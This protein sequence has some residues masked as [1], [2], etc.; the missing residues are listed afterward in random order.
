MYHLNKYYHWESEYIDL[1]FCLVY[2]LPD[3]TTV[4]L[5][6]TITHNQ[7]WTLFVSDDSSNVYLTIKTNQRALVNPMHA[8]NQF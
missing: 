2:N 8:N 6:N 1:I 3:N 4:W 7:L 5:T